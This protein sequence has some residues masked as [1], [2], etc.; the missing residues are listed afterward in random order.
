META[1]NQI[2]ESVFYPKDFPVYV[3]HDEITFLKGRVDATK[4]KRVRLCT[5][6]DVEDGLHEMLIVLSRDTYIRPAIHMTK[7]E[8]LFVV[9]GMADAIFFDQM[10]AIDEVVP[11]GDLN[12]N[13]RFYYRIDEPVF[14]TLIV[15]SPYFVFHESTQGPFKPDDTLSAPWSPSEDD[16]DA[17]EAYK[18]DL[19]KAI[20]NFIGK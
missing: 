4:L 6:R 10:G 13:R 8:S 18:I 2:N 11:L 14:H 16:T 9:E 15:R 1:F 19:D 17:C 3:G 12:T 5:H 20:N 7:A